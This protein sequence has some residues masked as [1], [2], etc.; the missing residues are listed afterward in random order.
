MEEVA[1]SD[2][3][4]KDSSRESSNHRRSIQ[5]HRQ[6]EAEAVLTMRDSEGIEGKR[7]QITK[8]EGT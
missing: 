8:A 4:E 2:G 1:E 6:Q 5:G 7:G 3:S